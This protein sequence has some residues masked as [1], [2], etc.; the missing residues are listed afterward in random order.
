M[1]HKVHERLGN[2]VDSPLEGVEEVSQVHRVLYLHGGG[3]GDDDHDDIYDNLI[4]MISIYGILYP[5][6]QQ[7]GGV[8]CQVG[9]GVVTL[10]ENYDYYHHPWRYQETSIETYLEISY[11][12]KRQC[13]DLQ[14]IFS[15][16]VYGK[17]STNHHLVEN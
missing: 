9:E 5:L 3:G 8:H 10:G 17:T 6:H 11:C 13:T 7:M 4:I 16:L 15:S 14:A 1:V 2:S 12:L